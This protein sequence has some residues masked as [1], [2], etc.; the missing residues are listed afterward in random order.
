[1]LVSSAYL[2]FGE[3]VFTLSCLWLVGGDSH[4][5]DSSGDSSGPGRV[6]GG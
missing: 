6:G 2:D 5:G 3:S 4:V 1:M